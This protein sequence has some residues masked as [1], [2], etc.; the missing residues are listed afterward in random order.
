MYTSKYNNIH[1]VPVIDCF[2]NGVY[3]MVDKHTEY[4]SYTYKYPMFIYPD[5]NDSQLDN[6]LDLHKAC[7]RQLLQYLEKNKE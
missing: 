7:K 4:I 6:S 1:T 3:S 5:I 2:S